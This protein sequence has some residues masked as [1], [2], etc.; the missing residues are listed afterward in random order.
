VYYRLA[1]EADPAYA[2]A[3][4]GLGETARAAGAWAD[5]EAAFT[6]ALT[7]GYARRSAA[8]I[9]QAWALY[10]QGRAADALPIAADAVRLLDAEPFFYDRYAQADTLAR[11]GFILLAEARYPLAEAVFAAAREQDPRSASAHLGT[12]L[13]VLMAGRTA[14]AR[15]S[16]DALAALNTAAALGW[17]D[18]PG[19]TGAAL[20]AADACARLADLT[21]LSGDPAWAAAPC[22]VQPGAGWALPG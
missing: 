3:H 12:G 22:A 15:A 2:A 6:R 1:L 9:E 5:A 16:S 17:N 14:D 18:V 4:Y 21:A 8:L 7:E 11:Y 13:A 10:Q 20:G 19:T